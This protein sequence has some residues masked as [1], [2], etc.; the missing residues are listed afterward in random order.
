MISLVATFKNVFTDQMEILVGRKNYPL[1]WES[2]YGQF[3]NFY[4]YS[5]KDRR[6]IHRALLRETVRGKRG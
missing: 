3:P 2:V 6:R 4:R 5:S 1:F